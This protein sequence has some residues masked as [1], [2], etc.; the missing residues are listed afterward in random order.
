[1]NDLVQK[2]K[3]TTPFVFENRTIRMVLGEDGESLFIAK[4]VAEAVDIVWQSSKSLEG[5]FPD[6]KRVV[7]NFPTTSGDKDTWALTE[8]GVY[9]FLGRAQWK[10]NP[11]IEVFQRWIYGEVLPS[12][13]K[14]ITER[15][16][17]AEMEL[18]VI[19][20]EMTVQRRNSKRLCAEVDDLGRQVREQQ[21]L[22]AH[23][24]LKPAY[25]GLLPLLA[26]E[27]RELFGDNDTKDGDA[28]C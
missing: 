4:D 1:M 19:Y 15:R 10:S 22:L 24:Q 5:I 7:G 17:L 27:Y 18:Q 26:K 25:Q 12:I 9:Q 2:G 11:K 3:Q 6:C 20:K 23:C 28:L 13:R 8:P 21:Q 14:N 16:L